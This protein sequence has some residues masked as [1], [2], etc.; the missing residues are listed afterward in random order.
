MDLRGNDNLIHIDCHNNK[1]KKIELPESNKLNYLDCKKN[2]LET[3]NC[4]ETPNIR[5]LNISVNPID[6]IDIR[7]LEEL[8]K[9]IKDPCVVVKH[10]IDQKIAKS[11]K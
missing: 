4:W 8:K 11:N 2:R 1:I 6:C 9:L 5:I 10:R 7:G 3:I